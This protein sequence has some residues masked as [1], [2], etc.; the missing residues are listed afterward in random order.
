MCLL[1]LCLPASLAAQTA[2][3]PKTNPVRANGL[4]MNDDFVVG[5]PGV[6][7][8]VCDS[9]GGSVVQGFYVEDVDGDGV[10]E[11]QIFVDSVLGTDTL[12]CGR[13]NGACRTLQHAFAVRADGPGDGQED[14]I[15]FAGVDATNF[16]IQQSGVAGFKT[17]PR[18]GATTNQQRSFQYPSQPLM[19]IGWDKDD[20][21]VYPPRDPDDTS[22]LNKTTGI[23]FNVSGQYDRVEVAHLEILEPGHDSALNGGFFKQQPNAHSLSH[24]YFHDL[25][26]DRPNYRKC[27]RTGNILWN[28]FSFQPDWVAAEHIDVTDAY[29]YLWRGSVN[30]KNVRF[31]NWSVTQRALGGPNT[32]QDHLGNRCVDLAGLTTTGGSIMRIWTGTAGKQNL[33]WIDNRLELVGYDSPPTAAKIDQGITLS[34]LQNVAFAGNLLRNY[35]GLPLMDMNDGICTVQRVAD[36]YWNNNTVIVDDPSLVK[37]GDFYPAAGWIGTQGGPLYSDGITREIQFNGNLID[38]SAVQQGGGI[39][40]GFLLMEN[41]PSVN[42][43]GAHLEVVGNKLIMD[44]DRLPFGCLVEQHGGNMLPDTMRI[45]D[46]VIYNPNPL[47]DPRI[48]MVDTDVLINNLTADSDYNSYYN[49]RF[50]EAGT[51]FT[52]MNAWRNNVGE[53]PNSTCGVNVNPIDVFRSDFESGNLSNWTAS[54]P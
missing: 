39:V 10:L 47:Y 23:Q 2:F 3:Y 31:S 21:G 35:A 32:N 33:E 42:M 19:L 50:R 46:N 22:R 13:P 40:D 29:G 4:D 27:H 5:E 17:L 8:L 26:I 43:T 6:D 11:E 34:C 18:Q 51:E 48:Y 15:C 7:D 14:I 25:Q 36:R 54:T 12:S 28:M 24:W 20:D 53:G 52:T 9:F 30:G 38:Y 37:P 16:E 45:R 41:T 1:L 49:C 44:C